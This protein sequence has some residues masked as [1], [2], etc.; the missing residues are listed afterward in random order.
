M[1][2]QPA[3]AIILLDF[4]R[5]KGSHK[6]APNI[7]RLSKRFLIAL[8][9]CW[10]APLTAADIAAAAQ[11][12]PPI[13]QTISVDALESAI[14]A[15]DLTFEIYG[16]GLHVISLHTQAVLTPHSYE[17]AS[18]FQTEGI[19]NTLFNGRGSSKAQGLLTPNGP[20]LLSYSQEY[21]G[22]FGERS[23][24]MMLDESGGYSVSAIPE[25]GVHTNGFSPA[26]VRNTV[27]PLTASIFTAVNSSADPCGQTISVFDGRRVFQLQFKELE[28]TRLT[29]QGAG[30]YQG[31]AWK[32]SLTYKPIAGYTRKWLVSQAR[33][34][35]RPF[36]VW[37]ARFDDVM[38]PS[39]N[40]PLVLPIRMLMETST[41]NATAHLTAATVDGKSLI[42][43]LSN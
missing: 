20:K 1:S 34:P 33:D 27:D 30:I 13:T 5:Q 25:D 17:I 35:I 32:C 38:G 22:R 7:Q 14:T 21:D 18:Q 31:N 16:G 8:V 11:P 43:A 41:V 12:V 36:T 28:A 37:L 24:A 19:A 4:H 26:T 23:I 10:P 40:Q 2:K 15:I 39:G 29:P 9:I 42:T 6:V 3:R